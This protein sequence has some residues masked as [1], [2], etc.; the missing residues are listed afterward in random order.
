MYVCYVYLIKINQSINYRKFI[1]NFAALA[2]PLTDLT[3]NGTPNQLTWT[4]PQEKAF[5]ALRSH[6]ACPPVLRLPDF[7]KEFI[8]QTDACNDGVGGVLFQEETGVKHPVA[9]ASKKLLPRERNYSTI[10]QECLAIVWAIQKFQ[11]FLYGKPFV[12]EADHQPLQYLG[13]AQFQNGRLMRLALALQPYRF[14]IKAVKSSENI[15]ADF[16][17]RHV[18]E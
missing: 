12:L 17:S 4:E 15:G 6:I 14:T 8:L 2:V 10:E 16:L 7:A 9:F 5:Q 11:N 18:A 3:K 1:P 13:K